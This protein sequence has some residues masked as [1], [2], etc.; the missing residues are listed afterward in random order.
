MHGGR[1][2]N[3]YIAVFKSRSATIGFANILRANNI[4]CAI[5]NTPTSL[6]KSCGISVKFLADFFNKANALLPYRLKTVFDGF[7]PLSS[8]FAGRI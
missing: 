1:K 5:I 6:D 7:Y 2:M 4:P 3:Y 8:G